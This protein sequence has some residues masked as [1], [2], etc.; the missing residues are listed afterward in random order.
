MGRNRAGFPFRMRGIVGEVES[1]LW[2]IVLILWASISRLVP[3]FS[4]SSNAAFDPV[5]RP[6]HF[7]FDEIIQG[8]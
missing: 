5:V 8:F 7:G 3:N 1:A 6:Q 4:S 2:G